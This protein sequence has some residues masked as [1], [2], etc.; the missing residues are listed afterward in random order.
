MCS[1]IRKENESV[2]LSKAVVTDED[3]RHLTKGKPCRLCRSCQG[4]EATA[5]HEESGDKIHPA[6]T[7][8][9]DYSEGWK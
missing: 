8:K 2:E 5:G 6:A 3:W 1:M 7:L 9:V 4:R